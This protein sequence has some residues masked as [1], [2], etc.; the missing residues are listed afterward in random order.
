LPGITEDPATA[1]KYAKGDLRMR[2]SAVYHYANSG[3]NSDDP[4]IDQTPFACV[5]S[6]YDPSTASTAR[7]ISS[8]PDDVSG[9]PAIG[10]R[11][12]FIGSNNGI[13]YPPR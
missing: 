3:F 13:A 4:V 7:N 11:Q 8:L 2:A 6:Y 12:A 9:D 1:R 5:S 10:A